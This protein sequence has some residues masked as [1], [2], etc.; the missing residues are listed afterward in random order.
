[1]LLATSLGNPALEA[2]L[3]AE[4]DKKYFRPCTASETSESQRTGI[5]SKTPN[6]R[7]GTAL[8]VSTDLESRRTSIR[9][10]ALDSQL[11]QYIDDDNVSSHTAPVPP[12]GRVSSLF[13][14]RSTSTSQ[15]KSSRIEDRINLD[16]M[17]MLKKHFDAA[18][19]DGVEGRL[20]MEL[21]IVVMSQL[22]NLPDEMQPQLK[23]LFMKIDSG[24]H[25]HIAWDAFCTYMQLELTEKEDSYSRAREVC[26]E[27]PAVTKTTPHRDT[28]HRVCVL[29]DHSYVTASQ[30]GVVA[31]W[32]PATLQVKRT[33]PNPDANK[34]K[35]KWITD[36]AM[37]TNINRFILSTG[38]RELQFFEASTFEPYCQI[39]GLESVPLKMSFW[40]NPRNT[41]ESILMY[42]DN[43]GCVNVLVIPN[44]TLAF[45]KWKQEAKV[46]GVPTANIEKVASMADVRYACWE[47]HRDWVVDLKYEDHLRSIISCSNDPSTGIVIGNVVGSTNVESALRENAMK[48]CAQ[49]SSARKRLSADQTVFYVYKG[50]KTFAYSESYNILVTGGMDRLVRIW[51]P[52]VNT[53][54]TA[55][56]RGHN[57]PIFYLYICDREQRIYSISTD[58]TVKVWDAQDH[59]QLCSVGMKS[60]V[61]QGEMTAVLYNEFTKAIAIT[62]DCLSVLNLREHRHSHTEATQTHR[63]AIHCIR[64]NPHFKQIVTACNSSMIKVWDIESGQHV[65]EYN[66]AHGTSAVTSMIFDSSGRR[67]VTG[68]RDGLLRIWNYNNGQCLRTLRKGS[69]EEVTCV[70]HVTVSKNKYIVCVGWDRRINVFTDTTDSIHHEQHALPHWV[71]DE[72]RGHTEDILA[73]TAN[74]ATN[75]L[76]TSSYDGEIIIW[77]LVSGHI[78][79]RLKAPA[80]DPKKPFD[81]MEG[82]AAVNTLLFLSARGT[83]R[84]AA[85]LVACG[86]AGYIHFWNIY[87]GGKVM[88]NFLPNNEGANVLAVNSHNTVL[89]S[90]DVAGNVKLYNISGYC[91]EGTERAPPPVLSQFRAHTSTIKC[92]EFVSGLTQNEFLLSGSDDCSVRLWTGK[93]HYIGTLG[94][95]TRWDIE[96]PETYAHPRVPRDVLAEPIDIPEKVRQSIDSSPE[97]NN[98]NNK[99]DLHDV[100]L[101]MEYQEQEG[102][103]LRHV[104][105]KP[106]PKTH[107]GPAVY[108][109][110]PCFELTDVP[111]SRQ[112]PVIGSLDPLSILDAV[113]IE[114]VAS[115]DLS[116]KP[117]TPKLSVKSR[118]S[119]PMT[120]K[121]KIA[122]GAG[123]IKT[124]YK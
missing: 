72:R 112:A 54:P 105:H 61:I 67:L 3:K 94:Q 13:S 98:K 46:D 106:G 49:G 25:G 122:N 99:N 23:A 124:S 29:P 91:T 74:S 47:V 80:P 35:Q 15:Y 113:E 11:D 53:K 52:Y 9:I 58:K 90:G 42:G 87:K 43:Q 115:E 26:F 81:P 100:D 101:D 86:P 22:L 10:S 66:N 48:R 121:M 44:T 69:N 39:S 117:F 109:S 4:M 63:D 19:A 36:F 78:F 45:R 108:H 95:T 119:S 34:P 50:V 8:G 62:T 111:P 103:R 27:T 84:R 70:I 71:D 68:G 82:D 41:E 17:Q 57:G 79:C 16:H 85:T 33:R 24:S 110:L 107:E 2:P 32:N 92:F 12:S 40:H 83:T 89:A 96:D 5:P 60:H 14:N 20:S 114:S 59:S 116:L 75:H 28:L 56:L 37:M 30:D 31:F 51:N 73:V 123:A 55:L 77:S 6:K 104:K 118:R 120:T 38:D 21:F 93:G 1:M 18:A 102:T 64:Y 88:S 65:F 76:A 97:Q 7:P